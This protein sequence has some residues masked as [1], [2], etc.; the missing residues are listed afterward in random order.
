MHK[1]WSS[2]KLQGSPPK[3]ASYV[4][5]VSVSWHY[6]E[7]FDSVV[8]LENYICS[9]TAHIHRYDIKCPKIWHKPH[10]TWP[11]IRVSHQI[12]KFDCQILQ[13]ISQ[14]FVYKLPL[15]TQ[16]LTVSRYQMYCSTSNLKNSNCASGEVK[17]L[18]HVG[19]HKSKYLISCHQT[20]C[21]KWI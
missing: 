18:S 5:S 8:N 17:S 12:P 11:E 14:D 20:R 13:Q 19:L 21:G 2:I 6:H 16:Y 4:E 9:V 10:M 7:L 1:A 3:W 15:I